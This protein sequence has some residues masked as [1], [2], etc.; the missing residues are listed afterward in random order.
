MGINIGIPSITGQHA[1]PFGVMQLMH[2]DETSH[3]PRTCQM[4]TAYDQLLDAVGEAVG[5]QRAVKSVMS[6]EPAENITT[7]PEELP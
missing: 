3:D 1:V 4:C 5:F 2:Q 7:D 6:A